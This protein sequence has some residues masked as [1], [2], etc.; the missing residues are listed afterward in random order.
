MSCGM[1]RSAT[2]ISNLIALMVSLLVFFVGLIIYDTMKDA[3]NI[4]AE[5]GTIEAWNNEIGLVIVY[6]RGFTIHETADGEVQ[7]IVRCPPD[8]SDQYFFDGP[9]IRRTFQAGYYPPV[10]RPMQFPAPVPVGTQC[11]LEVWGTWKPT[12]SISTKRFLI[13]QFP[14]VVGEKR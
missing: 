2:I 6:Q 13:D 12:F 8:G 3:K 9:P 14:F 4:E 7:R 5:P 10:K 11:V 1:G